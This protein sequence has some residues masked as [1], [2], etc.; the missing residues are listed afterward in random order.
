[1]GGRRAS[2]LALALS[3]VLTTA[4][5]AGSIEDGNAG[6]AA[7]NRGAYDEAI[8]L[9]TRALKA[10]D[11]SSDDQEFA[12]L[13]RG[14]AYLARGDERL[15]LS[16][17][18]KAAELKPDDPDV[19][20]E[21][22]A[23]SRH[24]AKPASASAVAAHSEWGPM[25]PLIDSIWMLEGSEP[26]GYYRYQEGAD[27]HT[28]SFTGLDHKGN[29]ISGVYTLDASAG[30]VE[31]QVTSQGRQ[32]DF[33]IEAVGDGFAQDIQSGNSYAR[34]VYTPAGADSFN[35]EAQQ[36]QDDN[37]WKTV[38]SY[39]LVEVSESTVDALGWKPKKPPGFLKQLL[40][41]LG[42]ALVQGAIDGVA[43]GLQP[44]Q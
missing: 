7:L 33:Q 8:R 19:K 29:Q 27:G 20:S 10:G 9:F 2:G 40:S 30:T 24:S 41:G 14:K 23:A 42:N 15:A 4:A 32:S 35:V 5:W 21:L 16:D 11:L 31:E 13:N 18:H 28:L 44:P 43:A 22:A 3:V 25:A 37:S 38:G 6:L 39:R 36:Y 1:M 34:I 26:L 12:Y 17:L